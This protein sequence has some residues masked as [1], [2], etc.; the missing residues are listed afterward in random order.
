MVAGYLNW[1]QATFAS[2]L[3]E[4]GTTHLKVTREIDGGLDTVKVKLPAVLTAD[5]RLNEVW[6]LI[7]SFV[8]STKNV[9]NLPFS[10]RD[11]PP[12]QTSWK[13]KRSRLTKNRWPIWEW[14]L[15]SKHKFW[16]FLN[17]LFDKPEVLYKV[18]LLEHLYQFYQHVF[19]RSGISQETAR[20]GCHC[21][22]VYKLLNAI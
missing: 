6:S 15:S 2:K 10:S 4:E 5:L 3:E 7:S 8:Q 12:F 21:I 20:K 9:S 19:R 22:N 1:A 17:R 14:K 11:T 18:S 13:P 16:R